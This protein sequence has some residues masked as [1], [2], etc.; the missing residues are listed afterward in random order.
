MWHGYVGI[1]D[2]ALTVAQRNTLITALRTLGPATD[3][4]PA[5]LMRFRARNDNKAAIFEALFQDQDWT[6]DAIKARLGSIFAVNPGLITH[7]TVSSDYGPAVTFQY[8]AGTSRL[9]MI[10]FAGVNANWEVSRLACTHYLLD[11]KAAWQLPA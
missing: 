5:R 4:Q 11:N 3:P 1:E 2:L 7:S 9:R 8:P 6:V 10:A